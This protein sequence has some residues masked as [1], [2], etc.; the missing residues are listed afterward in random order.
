[1]KKLLILIIILLAILG[2]FYFKSQSGNETKNTETQVSSPTPSNATFTFDDG[3]IT[4]S[5]GRSTKEDEATGL[6]DEVWLLEEQASGDLN[7]DG[8]SDTV[9]LLARSGGGSGTFIYIAGFVS[10]TVSYKGTNALFVGDRISPESVS[11][12]NGI[13]TFKYLDR[14]DDEP[15]SAEPTVEVVK[16]YIYQNGQFVEK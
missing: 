3:S 11:I 4:L 5:S 12:S 14:R 7:K 1:M 6:S 15:F 2:L 10:G 16:Q 13:A 8:K 9:V